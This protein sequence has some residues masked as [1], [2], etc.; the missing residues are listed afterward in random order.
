MKSNPN[1][2]TGQIR[3][4]IGLVWSPET[5]FADLPQRSPFLMAFLVVGGAGIFISLASR[6]LVMAVTQLELTSR[7]GE[8]QALQSL[9]TIFHLQMIGVLAS[10]LFLLLKWAFIAGLIFLIALLLDGVMTYRQAFSLVALTSIFPLMES[11]LL[12]IILKLKG[13]ENLHRAQDLQPP[14]G[15]NLIFR[16]PDIVWSTFLSN[17]NPFQI[18]HL[19]VLILGVSI[20]NRFSRTKSTFVVLP[21]WI[22]LVGIQLVFTAFSATPR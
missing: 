2:F 18:W 7:M 14:I 19:I 22:F 15:L 20:L 12:L 13:I 21:V 11:L 16:S 6:P 4:L 10:P 9:P 3:L 5:A 17:I 1:S 8:E